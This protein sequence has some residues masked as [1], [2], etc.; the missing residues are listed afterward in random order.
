MIHQQVGMERETAMDHRHLGILLPQA[1]RLR[2]AIAHIV[3]ALELAVEVGLPWTVMLAARSMARCWSIPIPS[4]PRSCWA[5][6]KLSAPCLVTYR[7]PTNADLVDIT[8]AAATE[9][10][11]PEAVA[12]AVAAGSQVS[13]TDLPALVA[14]S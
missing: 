11:G 6:P 4:W 7:L 13:Y 9:T 1:W 12:R 2:Q 8:L 14:A 10:I 3:R 5:R